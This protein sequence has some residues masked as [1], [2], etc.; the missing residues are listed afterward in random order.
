MHVAGEVLGSISYQRTKAEKAC[1]TVGD[2][3]WVVVVGR[4]VCCSKGATK[5]IWKIGV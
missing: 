4:L 3:G 5:R 1:V 2:Q